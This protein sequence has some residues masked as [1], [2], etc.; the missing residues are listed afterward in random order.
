MKK[1]LVEKLLS[2]SNEIHKNRKSNANF[3]HLKKDY[4]QKQSDKLEVSFDDMVEIIKM[5]LKE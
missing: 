1:K 2:A 3:I 4:I 5:R